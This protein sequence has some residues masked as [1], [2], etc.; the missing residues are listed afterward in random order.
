MIY[1]GDAIAPRRKWVQIA[2]PRKPVTRI[3]PRTAVCGRAYRIA[4]IRIRIPMGVAALSAKPVA[5]NSAFVVDHEMR[6]LAATANR[7]SVTSVSRVRPTHS[8][9]VGCVL[10]NSISPSYLI[11]WIIADEIGAP[12][13]S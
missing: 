13:V 5:A 11:S 9:A 12:L 3:A 7:A 2:P 1:G 4:Q 8:Q 10:T 6:I